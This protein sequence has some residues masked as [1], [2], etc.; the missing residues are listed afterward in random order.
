MQQQPALPPV[1]RLPATQHRALEYNYRTGAPRLGWLWCSYFGQAGDGVA[2]VIAGAYLPSGRL[3]FTMP[4][5]AT[6]V[7]EMADYD[8]RGPPYG[9]T[10]RYLRYPDAVVGGFAE[11]LG[12]AVDCPAAGCLQGPGTAHG[13]DNSSVPG[14]CSFPRASAVALCAAWPACFALSCNTGG[15][16]DC[17]ARADANITHEASGFASFLRSFPSTPLF[18]FAYGLGYS[19]AAVVGLAAAAPG[20]GVGGGYALGDAVALMAQL[21]PAGSAA[22]FV[23]AVFGEFLQCDGS[24]SPVPALP[25]RTLL[26]FA[27]VAAEPGGTSVPLA[28]AL[29]PL[30]VPGVERQAF[31]G[32]LRVWAGDGGP[33]AGCPSVTLKLVERSGG[34]GLDRGGEL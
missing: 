20:P 12:L 32:M 28:F 25:R 7:G 10:Y 27:K 11:L 24:A 21:S 5:D 22:D 30:R 31:P 14:Q 34:C 26:A 4:V 9:R 18:P 17:Q 15:R 23:V 13:C 2:D 16:A 8:M 6:Q 1:R 33:C 3:P 19:G 29:D